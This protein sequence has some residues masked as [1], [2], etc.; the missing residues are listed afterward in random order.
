MKHFSNIGIGKKLI[1]VLA[2]NVAVLACFM[3]AAIW[4]T[5]SN[6]AAIRELGRVSRM[7]ILAQ[8]V[9]SNEGA[10]AQRV[11][12]MVLEGGAD[13][14]IMD[15]LLTLR[16]DYM[17]AFAELKS[18]PNTDE[19]TRLLVQSD[20]AAGRWRDADNRVIGLLKDHRASEAARLHQQE[21]LPRFNEIGETISGYLSYSERRLNSIEEENQRVTARFNLFLLV[22]GL[23]A[24]AGALASGRVLS[25]SIAKPLEA[26]IVHLNEVAGGDLTKDAPAEFQA[27]GDEIG[28][29]ARAKQSMIVNLRQMVQEISSEIQTLSS[30]SA[31]LSARSSEM[32]HGSQ[33]ASEKTHSVAAAVEQMT[34]NVMSVAAGMEQTTTNLASVSTNT[35]QMTATIG[36]IA[37]NSE[38][39]RG[40]TE[41]A[42]RQAARISEQ[43]NQL[44]DAAREIGK[45][46]ETI[47]EI[48]SQTNL[49][50][51]NATIEAARAGAAG[52]GFAVV[53]NEI[54]E[55]AQQTAAATEDIKARIRGV[56]SSASGGIAE[57][58]KV[59]KVIHDVREIVSSIAAAIE[60][61]ATATKDIAHNIAEA[62]QGVRDANQR[63]SETSQATGDIAREIVEVDHAAVQVAGGSEH[64]R[65]SADRLARV[66][67]KLQSAV[68]R[69]H[70]CDVNRQM[71]DT[72]IAAH[73]AW[74]KRLRA[75]IGSGQLEVPLA[76]V[77]ADN[78]CQFGKWLYGNQLSGADKQ[79]ERCRTVKQLH[80][81]FHQEAAKVAQFAISRQ[82]AAAE[83]AMSPSSDYARVSS[84]L[85]SALRQWG[86]A[87]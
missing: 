4:T 9:S 7:T 52:K 49:L 82:K 51:L 11:A 83:G 62:S 79:T 36:E 74:E 65:T 6:D 53:A 47:T 75:A 30:S 71:I 56:Q 59:S 48:S 25:R 2:G 45:V 72:A 33:E 1:L 87:S 42:A 23:A 69:F 54:K 50:A 73:S 85:M 81:Q 3:G 12:T 67:E 26:A 64:V 66:A 40:V 31:E 21:V 18:L 13:P 34:A 24:L 63:V 28:L 32:S 77:Q 60:E 16:K 8:T 61:Q 29:L 27:R 37:A 20:E 5:R 17:A 14:K 68:A 80:A 15:R 39:A 43:M 46:T 35:E 84:A 22:G 38:K 70:V 76:T 10:I 41:D 55:L 44:G 86:A 57:I 78:Q 19:G 58:E